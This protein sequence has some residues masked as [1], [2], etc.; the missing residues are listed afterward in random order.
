[1]P[2]PH[3]ISL[4]LSSSA[5][6]D[7]HGTAGKAL[8]GSVGRSVEMA[9]ALADEIDDPA[10][11]L[12]SRDFLCAE[13]AGARG[14]LMSGLAGVRTEIAALEGRL[15]WRFFTLLATMIGVQVALVG[16]LVAVLLWA[17]R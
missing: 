6:S 11:G 7:E 16:V 1:M 15:I 10:T 4:W 12:V 17:F 13:M 3:G 2:K 9:E 8:A 5:G 14:E